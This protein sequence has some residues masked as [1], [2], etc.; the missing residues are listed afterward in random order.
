M[1][2]ATTAP[3][4]PGGRTITD[5]SIKNRLTKAATELFAEK[6]FA[7]TSVRDICTKADASVPMISH[8]FGSKKGLLDEILG[9]LSA[10]VFEVPLRIIEGD[11]NSRDEF[12]T[13]LNLF[14]SE[15]FNALLSLAPVFR[16]IAREGG[17]FADL[18][19][20][21]AALAEF[22]TV[23]QSKGYLRA[24]LRADMT[25]GLIF[26]RLGNQ[27]L[28]AINPTYKGPSVLD[29][30]TYRAQ[31]LAANIDALVNGLGT[32]DHPVSDG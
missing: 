9:T 2:L 27:V 30:K 21:H 31:W 17:E 29:D 14:I 26:D 28:F 5:P 6:G 4:K 22:M 15:V 13:K 7:G 3:G 25:T 23:A 20:V 10:D 18:G 11:L 32:Q 19:K 8:Y 12:L 24:D 16:I 1:N